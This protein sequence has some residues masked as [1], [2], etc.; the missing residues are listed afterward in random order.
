MNKPAITALFLFILVFLCVFSVFSDERKEN[1]DVFVVLDKSLSMEEEIE[2]VKS[3][4]EESIVE[5][6]L[7]PGDFFMLIAFYGQAEKMIIQD[8]SDEEIRG[9]FKNKIASIAA[10]G[11]FTDIG[12]A[13]DTL[14]QA[15]KEYE[16]PDR[17]QYLLLI[18]DGIQE[19]PPESKYYSEDG[20]FNHAFLEN[21]RIIQK[22]GWKIHILG[23]GMATAAKEIAEQLS[24]EYTEIAEEP[25]KELLEEKTKDFLGRIEVV[26]TPRFDS[27]KSNGSSSLR[28]VLQSVYYEEDVRITITD[29]VLKTSDLGTIQLVP[30]PVEIVINPENPADVSIPVLFP[31]NPESGEYSGEIYFSFSGDSSFSPAVFAVDFSVKNYFMSNIFWI[32][33]VIIIAA[34]GIILMIIFL[35]KGTGRKKVIKFRILQDNRPLQREPYSLREGEFLFIFEEKGTFKTSEDKPEKN[36]AHLEIRENELILKITEPDFFRLIDDLP[37]GTLLGKKIRIHSSMGGYKILFFRA[38]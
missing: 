16:H 37:E 6:I 36:H 11:R 13:L 12:N 33:P 19:A 8:M 18:T 5:N 3:Y 30:K 22:E 29:A 26:E 31:G 14:R 15:L 38:V 32:L 34:A 7:I 4:V 25:T 2:A 10:D 9:D 24:G 27:V 1:I 35:S 17:R 21:T 23:I 28:F 20:S